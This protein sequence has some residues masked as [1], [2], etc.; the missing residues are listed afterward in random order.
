MQAFNVHA[1]DTTQETPSKELA[2]MYFPDAEIRLGL[3]GS[4]A[5]WTTNEARKML[6]WEHTEKE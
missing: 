3:E 1:L 4:K 2:K 5:F 6:G